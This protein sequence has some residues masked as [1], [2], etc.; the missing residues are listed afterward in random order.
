MESILKQLKNNWFIYA[1]FAGLILWYGNMNSRMTAVEAVQQEQ[2]AA[3][4]KIDQMAIDMAVVK[5]D[6]G[7]IKE[8]IK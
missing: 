2:K 1:F 8:K 6:V 7:Y 5:T 3:L 4:S